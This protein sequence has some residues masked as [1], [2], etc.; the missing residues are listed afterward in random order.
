MRYDSL[1][2]DLGS[3]WEMFIFDLW[4]SSSGEKEKRLNQKQLSFSWWRIF[5]KPW[6]FWWFQPF[7]FSWVFYL[8]PWY[9][10]QSTNWKT[11]KP[12]FI[13]P[14]RIFKKKLLNNVFNVHTTIILLII[15]KFNQLCVVPKVK[16][17]F[18]SNSPAN[19]CS[20]CGLSNDGGWWRQWSWW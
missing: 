13:N 8:S 6:C 14:F 18:Q 1:E 2:Q 20:L 5:W 16:T 3:S 17:F 12:K 15:C 4:E 11:Y 10:G 7:L 19:S 9:T